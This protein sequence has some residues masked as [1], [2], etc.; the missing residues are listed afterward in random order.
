MLQH[1]PK[2]EASAKLLPALIFDKLSR[3][4]KIFWSIEE[5]S[6]TGQK[7]IVREGECKS[8]LRNFALLLADLFQFQNNPSRPY[9]RTD[10]KNKDGVY[11]A[12]YGD[13]GD[14][15]GW[16]LYAPIYVKGSYGTGFL[17]WGASG[18]PSTYIAASSSGTAVA[19]TDYNM[20]ANIGLA[21]EGIAGILVTEV[22]TASEFKFYVQKPILALTTDY[23]NSIGL[24]VRFNPGIF[25]SE[26]AYNPYLLFVRDIVSPAYSASMGNSF[27]VRFTFDWTSSS[28]CYTKNLAK[29]I[30]GILG[31]QNETLV[32]TSNVSFPLGIATAH[33]SPTDAQLIPSP[34]IMSGTDY[35]KIMFGTGATAPTLNDYH[36]TSIGDVGAYPNTRE[37]VL[38]QDG[39]QRMWQNAGTFAFISS[40]SD[41]AEMAYFQNFYERAYPAVMHTVMLMRATFSPINFNV[42]DSLNGKFV[43]NIAI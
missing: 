15:G 6:P 27:N 42:G 22:D 12:L 35:G 32:D 7:K 18:L 20:T 40:Q 34:A 28:A 31:G 41:V 25:I 13:I 1:F 30:R 19:S 5:V 29:I 16:G 14:G 38:I 3:N 17:R 21:N 2:L 9:N 36:I 39:T 23:V 4:L 43:H 10:Y 33:S 8:L 26:S 11:P 37:T 24:F